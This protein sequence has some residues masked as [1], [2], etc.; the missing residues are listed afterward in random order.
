MT[1][2]RLL[3]ILT[4]LIALA[5]IELGARGLELAQAFF[6]DPA[7][8][9]PRA[10]NPVPVFERAEVDGRS[11]WR[12]TR[13]HPLML[14]TPQF[15]AEK[16]PG[17]L[18]VFLLG[19]SAAGGWPFDVG[20]YSIADQL[21][22]KLSSLYPGRSIEVLNAAGGT[23]GSHRV[24]FVFEEIIEHEPDLVV[25]YSGNNE[26]LETFVYLPPEPP[27]PWSHLALARVPYRALAGRRAPSFDVGGY[28][29]ADQTSNRLAFAFG[30]GSR[31]REDPRQLAQVVASFRE[32][33]D[34]MLRTSQERGVPVLL[35]NVP[36]NLKDW[37]PNASRHRDGLTPAERARWQELFRS[38]FVA[39]EGERWAEAAAALEQA[40]AVDDEH[41][42]THYWLGVAR[43]RLG[44]TAD[45]RAA[46]TAA[47]ERD[48]FPF[49][50]IPALQ[51]VL[52]TLAAARGVPLV[53]VVGALEARAA[54]GILGLDVMV[55]YVHLSE[56]SQELVAQEIL[57]RMDAEGLLRPRPALPVGA[58]APELPAGFRAGPAVREIELLYRQ[59]LVMRQYD[60]LDALF[61]RYADVMTR[62]PQVQPK[63]ADY[64]RSRLEIG[65]RIQQVIGPYRRL[66]RAEKLGM[67][68][69]TFTR[70]E[71]QRV[72]G[73][74][75]ALVRAIEAPD[76]PREEFLQQVPG[77]EWHGAR[78]GA[79]PVRR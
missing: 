26:F 22:R 50:A 52:V 6:Q 39:L 14:P 32:N 25:I 58:L 18:R 7:S 76:M 60:K 30:R 72:Y 77:L 62:A 12:R 10:T 3:A 48:A 38:G 57:R 19:G 56:A 33:V 51:D 27:A 66:L 78:P 73:A 16:P 49:R 42:E 61:E 4:A 43:Q 29:L 36:V 8:Q 63:L 17:G 53:D 11:V 20:G 21:A 65:Q 5:A 55:D 75:V 13:H 47:L 40:A 9:L 74:Y 54:D 23:Y 69:Q 59:H 15:A 31:Y 67:V 71:A 1:R 44:R 24:R 45:A 68:E 70:E 34:F 64:C 41:A 79:A 37:V 46:Y 35:L 28:D 2:P